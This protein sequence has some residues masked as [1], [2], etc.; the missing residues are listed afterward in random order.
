MDP[1]QVC[2]PTEACPARGPGGNGS[3]TVHRRQQA[4]S[5]CTG[6]AKTFR[7]RRGTMC[8]WQQTPVDMLV[9]VVTLLAHGCP[10]RAMVAAFGVTAETVRTWAAEA[11]VHGAQV[12]RHL[13]LGACWS[14]R[15]GHADE[16]RVRMQQGMVWM[17]MALMVRTRLWLGGVVSAHRDKG[18]IR[19]LAD[20]VR[21]CARLGA[22]LVAVD[23]LAAS[24]NAFRCAVRSKAPRKGPGRP[25]LAPWVPVVIGGGHAGRAR[26]HGGRCAPPGAGRRSGPGCAV[27]LLGRGSARA[28]RRQRAPACH[29]PLPPGQP[30][31]ASPLWRPAP[32]HGD[33]GHGPGRHGVQLLYAP[34]HPDQ[35]PGPSLPTG[36]GRRPHPPR[37]DGCGIAS[38]SWAASTLAA[39]QT[40]RTALQRAANVD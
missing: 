16:M 36:H 1:T 27:G 10:V 20:R 7:A 12:H 40:T 15:H 35:R 33:P 21:A 30:G 5:R 2:C 38:R 14:L 32:P 19:Q 37:L 29:R 9:L 28:H 31:A 8:S 6:C 22:L 11:G 18:L 26:S 3:I 34:R 13:V 4:R 17:A 39:A 25:H 24:V 23:G